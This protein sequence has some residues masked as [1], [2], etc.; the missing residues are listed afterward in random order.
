M[1]TVATHTGK[2]YVNK[3]RRLEFLTVGDYGKENNI[4]ADFLGLYQEINGVL[5]RP[6]DL[7]KK[8]V[9]TISSQKGCP[10]NCQFCDCPKYGFYGN[11]T[12]DDLRYQIETILQNET[13]NHTDR[14]NVHFA[15]MGEPTFNE[16]ILVFTQDELRDL[17]G[18]YITAKTIH[19]VVSTMLPKKN[20][21]LEEFILSWCSIKNLDYQ[22]EAGL[23][24]S[25]NSTDDKQ[26]N[27]QFNN[28]S[29]SLAE[30]S[31]LAKKL[32]MP[33]GRKYT[34]NFA[35]TKDTILDAKVLTNLFSLQ[36]FIVKITPVHETHSAIQNGFDVTT[37]YDDYDV[38][39]QFERPLVQMGWDVIVFVPSHEEDQDRITCGNALISGI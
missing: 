38:Y 1:R 21:A 25:I 37:S 39:R 3:D 9:A 13:V 4:K 35:V 17:V 26:R 11:A 30:I 33:V 18:K 32:P 16:N 29:L 24:F 6:V 31:E 28:K 20:T 5:H 15:R 14:F 10:M 27:F 23:Q 36:K 7:V 8:W 2:I 19:P 34:L 12:L 22:G